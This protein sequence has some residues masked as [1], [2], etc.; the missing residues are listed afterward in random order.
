MST[1]KNLVA[2]LPRPQG[3]L[4]QSL[5]PGTN[6]SV[7]KRICRDGV[8]RQLPGG[9]M[10]RFGAFVHECRRRIRIMVAASEDAEPGSGARS[11]ERSEE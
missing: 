4:I 2:I 8:M 11:H 1:L 9:L 6:P 7:K 3:E 10:C 5:V